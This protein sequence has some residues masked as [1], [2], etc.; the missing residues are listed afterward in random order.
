MGAATTVTLSPAADLG[1]AVLTNGMPIGVPESVASAF[2]DLALDGAVSRDWPALYERAFAGFSEPAI[3]ARAAFAQ[4]PVL[5]KPSLAASA[6]VG[7]Y[8][9]DYFGA[10]EIEATDSGFLLRQGPGRSALSLQH[11]DGD[12]FV[13]ETIGENAAGPSAVVFSVGLDQKATSLV[14]D[15]LNVDGN[16]TFTRVPDF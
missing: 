2:V 8:H 6:Y 3:R 7:I 13:Y 11:W 5:P 16:G 14:I 12:T 9:N 15:H 1:I 4:P 10:V